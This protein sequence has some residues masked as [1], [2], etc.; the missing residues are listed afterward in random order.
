M[1]IRE[2]GLYIENTVISF[3]YFVRNF[4]TFERSGQDPSNYVKNVLALASAFFFL[5][6]LKVVNS[7]FNLKRR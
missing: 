6:K 7:I 3:L 4:H 1:L 2:G 5:D